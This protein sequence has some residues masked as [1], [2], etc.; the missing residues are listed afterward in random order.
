MMPPLVVPCARLNRIPLPNTESSV[1]FMYFSLP[2]R[3]LKALMNAGIRMQAFLMVGH[4]LICDLYALL[5][6]TLAEQ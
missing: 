2:L 1:M 3:T 4:T 6:G 5:G